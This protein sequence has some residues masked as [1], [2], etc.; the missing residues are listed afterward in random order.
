[1]SLRPYAVRSWRSSPLWFGLSLLS[2]RPFAGLSLG[3]IGGVR[4]GV[5]TSLAA[6]KPKTWSPSWS[7]QEEMRRATKALKAAQD[8][9]S[10]AVKAIEAAGVRAPKEGQDR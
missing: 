7:P 3:S 8:R 10:A 9:Y 6:R 1:M 5:V 4:L 2:G